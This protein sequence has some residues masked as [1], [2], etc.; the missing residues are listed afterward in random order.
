MH[1]HTARL[2]AVASTATMVALGAAGPAAADGGDGKKHGPPAAFSIQAAV[3]AAAPGDTVR[4]PPGTYRESI[5]IQQDGISLRGG[6][7]VVIEPAGAD[8]TA[9]D[10]LDDPEAD[11]VSGI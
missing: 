4:I 11:R 5:T 6:R 2:L 7:G 10:T 1:I 9:C 8:P 3:D